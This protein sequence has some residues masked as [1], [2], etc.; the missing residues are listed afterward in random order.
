MKFCKKYQEYMQTQDQKKLP[1]MG[2]KNLKKILKRC[3]TDT[4]PHRSQSSSSPLINESPCGNSDTCPHHCPVCDGTFFPS[5]MKDT[6]AVVGCFN[7]RA[8]KLLD[9][10]LA[11]GFR[12]YYVWCRGKLQGSHGALVQEGKDLVAYAII[13]AIA[14]R[15]ILKKYDKIHYSKHGQAFRSQVQSMHMEILKSP[16][17]CELIAFHINSKETNRK[18]Y[19]G[20]SLVFN[21]GKPSLSCELSDTFKIEIDL[22]CSIC[23]DTVF[24]SVSLTCGHIFCYMCACKSGSVTIVDGLQAA[25][26]TA[27]CP[28]CREAGVYEGGLHLDELNILLSRRCP[29][30][31]EERLQNERVE[32]I[33]QAKEHWE[34]QSRAFLGI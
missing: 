12:K 5:L 34:S 29:E 16:W 20:P 3:R 21:D 31:W 25:R 1:A 17:L 27:K 32:R 19:E 8:Q 33:Q 11:T 9:V 28:L 10:H 14:L 24:D 15:K 26:S 7:K 13:N 30:Y 18:A 4:I 6:S 2:F 23:L 22:T